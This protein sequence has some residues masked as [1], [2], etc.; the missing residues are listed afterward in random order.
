VVGDLFSGD[1][2]AALPVCDYARSMQWYERFLGSEPSFLPNEIEAV[3]ELA[4]H[5]FLYIVES[6]QHAGHAMTTVFVADLDALVSDIDERD[7]HPAKRETLSNG[8]RK[9]T[10]QD[11]D[12]NEITFGGAPQSAGQGG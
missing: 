1:L 9:A 3:W 10:F 8:V 4:E 7:I 2:F 11:P 5:R 12:G 6:P